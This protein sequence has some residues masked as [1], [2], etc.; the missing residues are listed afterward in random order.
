[1]RTKLLALCVVLCL[2]IITSRELAYA[3]APNLSGPLPG[4]LRAGYMS[5][6]YSDMNLLP[7]MAQVGMNAALPKYSDFSRP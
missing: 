7:Q 4:R 5:D 6:S 1:M 2:A 3:A